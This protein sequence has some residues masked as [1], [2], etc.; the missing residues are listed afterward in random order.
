MDNGEKGFF[1]FLILFIETQKNSVL[2][3][4]IALSFAMKVR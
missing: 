4:I 3:I 2:K 1:N